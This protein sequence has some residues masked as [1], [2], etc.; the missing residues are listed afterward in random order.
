[1]VKNLLGDM[2]SE[3][4]P[5][6][7]DDMFRD[8]SSSEGGEEDEYGYRIPHEKTKDEKAKP[9][10]RPINFTRTTSVEST[11]PFDEA[12]DDKLKQGN[13][14][15]TQK[16]DDGEHS[17][18]SL[19]YPP[20]TSYK[21]SMIVEADE[22]SIGTM[23]YLVGK[24]DDDDKSFL[25]YAPSLIYP[26]AVANGQNTDDPSLATYEQ[27]QEDD[28]DDDDEDDDNESVDVA[29]QYGIHSVATMSYGGNSV[30]V[31]S[32]QYAVD[33]DEERS[34]AN[35][36]VE[37][38]IEDAQNTLPTRSHSPSPFDGLDDDDETQCTA[39]DEQFQLRR[40][41]YSSSSSS[42]ASSTDPP[43][44]DDVESQNQSHGAATNASRS[45]KSSKNKQRKLDPPRE[46]SVASS[47]KSHRSKKSQ[48]QREESVASS[49]KSHRSKKSQGQLE[50]SVA[51]SRKSHRSKKKSVPE[52]PEL[53][54]SR[55][56]A[57]STRSRK[58]GISCCKKCM[59]ISV[60]TFILLFVGAAIYAYFEDFWGIFQSESQD[61]KHDL[62]EPSAPTWGVFDTEAPSMAPNNDDGGT[63]SPTILDTIDY[64]DIA[65]KH[66]QDRGISFNNS[67][68]NTKA[69]N[70]LVFDMRKGAPEELGEENL[71][72]ADSHRI[73]ERFALYVLGLSLKAY[74]SIDSVV[75][76][77]FLLQTM[78]TSRL[79]KF[80]CF[81][82]GVSCSTL[83]SKSQI[84][85]IS[86]NNQV[87]DGTI[88][89][90][91]SLLSS[92]TSLDLSKNVLNGTIPSALF[93]IATLRKVYLY[94]NQFSGEIPNTVVQPDLSHLHL[95][96]NK[97]SGTIPELNNTGLRYLNLYK[98]ELTGFIPETLE[99]PSIFYFDV[100]HNSLSG[101]L[102]E[103]FAAAATEVRHIHLD[104]NQLNGTLPESY[105]NAGSQGL[106][107]LTVNDNELTGAVPA[108][109]SPSMELI[110]SILAFQSNSR[111][112]TTF[113]PN[114]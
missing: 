52:Q 1:M 20:Y 83:D 31:L 27:Q 91:I 68:I 11:R 46:E 114:N 10:H 33:D 14:K 8:S 93:D 24:D 108:G 66:L 21:P 85:G 104:H 96:H 102:P 5:D 53:A 89:S 88:P 107:T 113:S 57:G 95:S 2:D 29:S 71:F 59:L 19:S 50:E 7:F 98:N 49:R 70:W 62:W 99:L 6:S 36:S 17:M 60:P 67:A 103:A 105:V 111:C 87:L 37:F 79:S 43:S 25:S 77:D 109:G 47:R 32:L 34:L 16:E 22:K 100:G 64:F 23:S 38:S 76:S 75:K 74:D 81:W 69:L 106:Y 55:S 41:N 82:V 15:V 92:L 94:Q 39:V 58:S 72:L 3:A 54:L 84:T 4:S 73:S 78:Q 9:K 63:N 61:D 18:A 97:L 12:S 35:Q 110:I 40:Y 51:S 80:H 13:Q 90:E 56:G 44:S 45:S 86:I 101:A 42:H 30:S 65:S 48:E 112:K 26:M 28:D